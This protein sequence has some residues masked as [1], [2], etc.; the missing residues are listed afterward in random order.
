MSQSVGDTTIDWA[1]YDT[2]LFFEFNSIYYYHCLLLVFLCLDCRF[3]VRS[4]LSLLWVN[5]EEAQGVEEM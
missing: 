5:N 4:V 1:E 2:F 3:G